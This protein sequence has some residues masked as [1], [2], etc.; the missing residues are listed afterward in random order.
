MV[1]KQRAAGEHPDDKNRA[2]ASCV[3]CARLSQES[4]CDGHLTLPSAIR[5]VIKQTASRP[6]DSS[7]EQP[8]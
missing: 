4:G 1:A 5:R 8:I 6:P 2:P 7:Q 3:T